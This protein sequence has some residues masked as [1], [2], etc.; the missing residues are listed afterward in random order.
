VIRTFRPISA[1]NTAD[2]RI[3]PALIA[4]DIPNSTGRPIVLGGSPASIVVLRNPAGGY[5]LGLHS[6]VSGGNTYLVA[7]EGAEIQTGTVERGAPLGTL[8]DEVPAG[9]AVPETGP[10]LAV[11]GPRIFVP[12]DM[13][14]F[15]RLQ[16]PL[17][18]Q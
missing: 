1:G 7:P 11:E 9:E 8:V 17:Q 12:A 18:I 14:L 6:V 4:R 13:L 3:Y 15:F 2:Q 10:A 16:T 5:R